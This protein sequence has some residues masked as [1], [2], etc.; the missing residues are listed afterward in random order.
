MGHVGN[1]TLAVSSHPSSILSGAAPAL[2]GRVVHVLRLPRGAPA[3]NRDVSLGAHVNNI[4][5]TEGLRGFLRPGASGTTSTRRVRS[6]AVP[7][8]RAL[9]CLIWT[10]LIGGCLDRGAI[11]LNLRQLRLPSPRATCPASSTSR[12]RSNNGHYPLLPV[13]RVAEHSMNARAGPPCVTV[14]WAIVSDNDPCDTR[15]DCTRRLPEGTPCLSAPGLRFCRHIGDCHAD[16]P[17]RAPP[18]GRLTC[19]TPA[20]FTSAA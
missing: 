3:A 6:S 17:L 12:V 19:L 1:R 8:R 4:R 11:T 5:G 10:L 15:L 9:N 14:R 13:L 7:L 16:P 2:F 18:P 20:C